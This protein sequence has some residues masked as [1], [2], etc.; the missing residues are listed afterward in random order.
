MIET[1]FKNNKYILMLLIFKQI[2]RHHK[3]L[4]VNH[5]KLQ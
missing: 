2:K 3:N 5:N 4:T 1:L